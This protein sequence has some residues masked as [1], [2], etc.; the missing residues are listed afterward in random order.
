MRR[1]WGWERVPITSNAIT[2]A[3]AAAA[4]AAAT[5]AAAAAAAVTAT[6]SSSSDAAAAAAA[7]TFGEANMTDAGPVCAH[8]GVE[9]GLR[10]GRLPSR[11]RLRLPPGADTRSR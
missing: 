11:L 10:P 9:H 8:R 2:A 6:A 4:A 7:V 1:R 3:A 5:T